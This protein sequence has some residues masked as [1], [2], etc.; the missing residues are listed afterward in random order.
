MIKYR[1][2]AIDD[3][4]DLLKVRIDFLLDAKNITSDNEQT[5][6]AANREYLE[7]SLQDGS[8]VGWL[9]IDRNK[10][11]ATSSVSYYKLPPNSIRPNGK[12]AY[13]GSMF[14]YPQ[15]RKQGI[16]TKLFEMAV[17]DAKAN[18]YT[19][20]ELHATKMGRPIYEK[21]GF[22]NSSDAMIYF[23]N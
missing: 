23:A 19:Q 15:Y 16:A 20:I 1:K 7:S 8:F 10:I 18:G 6:L 3:L 5:M 9:A 4:D 13:I 2:A 17:K 14:T 12:V 22:V 21:Y 11:I